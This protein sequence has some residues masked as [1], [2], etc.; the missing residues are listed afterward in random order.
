MKFFVKHL[1]SCVAAMAFGALLTLGITEVLLPWSPPGLSLL[2]R[3]LAA[4][5]SGTLVSGVIYVA[6][7]WILGARR[8]RQG[9]SE[10]YE[11]AG[12]AFSLAI[13]AAMLAGIFFVRGQL[14]SH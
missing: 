5:M 6:A 7:T 14:H 2:S 9:Y 8:E 13:M 12:V 1:A 11:V 3:R 4:S 10:P